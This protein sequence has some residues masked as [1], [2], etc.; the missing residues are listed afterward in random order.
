[1]HSIGRAVPGYGPFLTSYDPFAKFLVL[2]FDRA[3]SPIERMG[4]QP[5]SADANYGDIS[6]NLI[7]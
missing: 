7:G 2:R 6:V 3:F 5:R 1:M 4:P